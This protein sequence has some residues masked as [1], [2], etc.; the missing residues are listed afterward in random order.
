[1]T[2]FQKLHFGDMLSD[3]PAPS[4]TPNKVVLKQPS[5]YYIKN[6][7]N[8]QLRNSAILVSP[9]NNDWCL[10]IEVYEYQK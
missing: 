1:M 8:M 6:E 4:T 9:S 2:Q 3:L 5:L 10:L 7:A